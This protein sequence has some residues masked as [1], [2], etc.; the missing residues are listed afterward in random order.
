VWSTFSY[1]I[2]KE[3]SKPLIVISSK[4]DSLSLIH[5]FSFGAAKRTGAVVLLSIVEALTKV[6]I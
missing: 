4:M 2:S 3:S 6:R 5:D 1:S